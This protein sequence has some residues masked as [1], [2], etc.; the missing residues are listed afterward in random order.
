MDS[1]I[2]YQPPT[3]ITKQN[4]KGKYRD[5]PRDVISS[6]KHNAYGRTISIDAAKIHGLPLPQDKTEEDSR[7]YP[8]EFDLYCIETLWETDF[9]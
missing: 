4:L 7:R 5:I 3:G 2:F 6:A 8:S 1:I 9:V